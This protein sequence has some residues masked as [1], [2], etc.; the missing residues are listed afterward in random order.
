MFRELTKLCDACDRMFQ[1]DHLNLLWRRAGRLN[2]LL[3][4]IPGIGTVS[5]RFSAYPLT[6]VNAA[7]ST[8][9]EEYRR[10]LARVCAGHFNESLRLVRR[11]RHPV[12]Q[13]DDF[14]VS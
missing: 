5:G 13:Q 4:A 7:L 6:G 2:P 12:R 11:I 3:E 14:S 9:D 10:I 8:V 1:P